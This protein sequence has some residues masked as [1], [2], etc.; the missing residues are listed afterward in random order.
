MAQSS[1]ADRRTLESGTR[2]PDRGGGSTWDRGLEWLGGRAGVGTVLR[3]LRLSRGLT[4]VEVARRAGCAKSYVSAIE[5]GRQAAPR[6]RMLKSLERAV[7]APAGLLER[8][9]WLQAEPLEAGPVLGKLPELAPSSPAAYQLDARG[10]ASPA[11]PV[12]ARLPESWIGLRVSD[13]RM[14]PAYEPGD[15][16]A[17]DRSASA[18]RGADVLAMLAD[19]PATAARDNAAIIAGRWAFARA[20]WEKEHGNVRLQPVNPAYRAR[21]VA[22]RRVRAMYPAVLLLRPVGPRA[23]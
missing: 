2:P 3:Q 8:A 4:L 21:A 20:Y 19:V 12:P 7:D 6:P 15:V 13:D 5:R 1:N 22:W 14:S 16:V 10:I 23:R 18:T 11:G 9:A 17:F